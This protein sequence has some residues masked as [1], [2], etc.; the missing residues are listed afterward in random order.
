[1]TNEESKKLRHGPKP[2]SAS[3]AS[4]SASPPFFTGNTKPLVLTEGETDV[5]HLKTALELLGYYDILDRVDI[6]WVGTYKQGNASYGGQTGLNHTRNLYEANPGL[7]SRRLL[8]LYDC[9][10]KKPNEDIGLLSVRTI[11]FNNQNTMIRKGIENLFPESVFDRSFYKQRESI[12]DYGE[13]NI[14]EE[15]SKKDF[16]QVICHERRNPVDFASFQV[17]ADIIREFLGPHVESP[18]G[19]PLV[20]EFEW[21]KDEEYPSWFL[22]ECDFWP[23]AT[24]P[25]EIVVS[26]PDVAKGF[27]RVEFSENIKGPWTDI[28]EVKLRIT[29]V[30][31]QRTLFYLRVVPNDESKAAHRQPSFLVGVLPPDTPRSVLNQELIEQ[32]RIAS[33][34]AGRLERAAYTFYSRGDFLGFHSQMGIC[35]TFVPDTKD[36][37]SYYP[38]EKRDGCIKVSYQGQFGKW[39]CYV[40][41]DN[42]MPIGIPSKAI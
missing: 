14:F 6:E 27:G 26:D 2:E 35:I 12:G 22:E 39:E 29:L 17:V 33:L 21:D 11:P 41:P 10:A 23:S 38:Q 20:F 24:G 15:F 30:K 7:L 37:V 34:V 25:S 16:V 5:E 42:L 32:S 4:A 1:M 19:D 3:K 9:D 31:D 8:L 13:R 36:Q 28:T 18:I 40:R